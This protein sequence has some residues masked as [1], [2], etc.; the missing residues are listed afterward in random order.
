MLFESKAKKLNLHFESAKTFSTPRRL[1]L[2]VAN[3]ADK[4]QDSLET[5]LGPSRKAA[6]DSEGQPTKAAEG[7]ARSKGVSVD[8]LSLVETA[9]GEYLQLTREV[10]G[11]PSS[12]LLPDLLKEL[13]F[14]LS[15]AKSMKWGV[16]KIY[17]MVCPISDFCVTNEQ[18]VCSRYIGKIMSETIL[19][20]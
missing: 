19:N 10:K 9:R 7:F 11:E 5:S 8:E 1:A 14:E 6:Y 15:F 17:E 16:L 18:K 20:L 2:L 12:K 4:Q 13:I 3:L